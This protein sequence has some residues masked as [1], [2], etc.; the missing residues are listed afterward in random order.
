MYTLRER[1]QHSNWLTRQFSSQKYYKLL[2]HGSM[3]SLLRVYI[4]LNLRNLGASIFTV[5]HQ[6][7]VNAMDVHIRDTLCPPFSFKWSWAGSQRSWLHLSLIKNIVQWSTLRLERLSSPLFSIW[8]I[9]ES[10]LIFEFIH[11]FHSL[12]C[13]RPLQGKGM[14]LTTHKSSPI[15]L[16]V[17]LHQM[18]FSWL[19]YCFMKA[20]PSS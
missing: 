10:N 13:T 3:I 6:C 17:I 19:V 5:S 1:P 15:I 9:F 14:F 18:H 2:S 12:T 8:K 4:P 20:T 7:E 11:K 16:S